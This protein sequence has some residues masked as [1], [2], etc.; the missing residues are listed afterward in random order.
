MDKWKKSLRK[1][2]TQEQ[3]LFVESYLPDAYEYLTDIGRL[4]TYDDDDEVVSWGLTPQ[5]VDK[6]ED[7][8]H[9]SI[10]ESWSCTKWQS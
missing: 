9:E 8:N 1:L 3:L 6:K 2:N 4:P 5:D 10:S 7:K